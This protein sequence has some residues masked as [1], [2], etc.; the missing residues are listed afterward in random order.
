M[1]GRT[2]AE[3]AF[4]RSNEIVFSSVLRPF[5][6]KFFSVRGFCIVKNKRART[7]CQERLSCWRLRTAHMTGLYHACCC[8]ARMPPPTINTARTAAIMTLAKSSTTTT[9]TRCDDLHESMYPPGVEMFAISLPWDSR[10]APPL[11][12]TARCL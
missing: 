4:F 11:Y 6:P 8:S 1:S 12:R 7:H 9:V 2:C 3:C 10:G 5:L